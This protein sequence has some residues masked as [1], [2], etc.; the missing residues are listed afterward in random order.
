MAT[1][2]RRLGGTS[3]AAGR[4]GSAAGSGLPE[5]SFSLCRPAAKR[6]I[7]FTCE[8][9]DMVE[10]GHGKLFTCPDVELFDLARGLALRLELL[11]DLACDEATIVCDAIP[12]AHGAD[13]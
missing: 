8:V 4:S 2:P 1:L 12:E 10:T 11:R 13:R 7:M 9:A 5:T 3:D 6:L